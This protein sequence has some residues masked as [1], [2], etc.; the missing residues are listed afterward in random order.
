VGNY[1]DSEAVEKA[2]HGTQAVIS[3]IGPSPKN[4]GNPKDHE[5][6]MENLVDIMRRNR[7]LHLIHIGGAVHDNDEKEEWSLSRRFLRFVLDIVYSP[8]LEAKRLEM[9]SSQKGG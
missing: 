4:Q 3:T 2:I 6:A 8:G 7:V 9:A 1:F 5:T